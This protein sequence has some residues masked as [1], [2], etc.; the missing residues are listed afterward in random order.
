MFSKVYTFN[1]KVRDCSL[2]QF[3][4]C[5][6]IFKREKKNIASDDDVFI[7]FLQ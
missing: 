6:L 4:F 2:I 7:F 1:N 3:I 5:E